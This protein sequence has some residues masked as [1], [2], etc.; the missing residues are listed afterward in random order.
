MSAFGWPSALRSTTVLMLSWIGAVLFSSAQASALGQNSATTRAKIAHSFLLNKFYDTPTPLPASQPGDLIR[1]VEFDGYD[2]PGDIS[3]VRILYHSVS[4][5][6]VDVPVSGVVLV[7]DKKP[8]SGGWPVIAWAHDVNGVGRTC[9]PS[10]DRNL[11]NGSFLSMYVQLGYAVVATDYAGLGS[12]TRSAFADMKS[13]AAD[14]IYAVAAARHG[15]PQL[16]MRWVAMGTGE[17]AMA[18]VAVGER[19]REVHDEG[20]L[21]SIAISGLQDLREE[22]EHSNAVSMK[23]L[24]ELM[25]GV[26]TVFPAFQPAAVLNPAGLSLYKGIANECAE[27]GAAFTDSSADPVGQ[28]WN[29]DPLIQAYFDRNRL[30]VS[31]AKAPILV[32]SSQA[33]SHAGDTREIVSRLCAVGDKVQFDNYPGSD[34]GTLI[35]DSVRDQIQWIE[36]AFAGRSARN[37]CSSR[38]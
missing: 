33:D 27:N 19:E 8:P 13:N 6:H 12:D 2:L 26:A 4:A 1:S 17:G 37:D 20:Y 28:K 36:G 29:G 25:Y 9:A 15:V 32:L 23:A 10:L 35:G 7:P 22:Y 21:G 18:A 31:A 34:P 30:G 16:G 3:A 5:S 11:R 24:L 14:V 38:P